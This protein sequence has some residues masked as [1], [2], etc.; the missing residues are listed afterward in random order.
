M[1]ANVGLSDDGGKK[2][3]LLSFRFSKRVCFYFSIADRKILEMVQW[4]HHV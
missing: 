3:K 1:D 2:G 4:Q